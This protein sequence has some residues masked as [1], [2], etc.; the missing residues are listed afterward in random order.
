MYI[1]YRHTY[2]D[3]ER[4]TE[5]N[6]E[7]QRDRDTERQRETQGER[8]RDREREVS[9]RLNLKILIVNCGYCREVGSQ[10]IFLIFLHIFIFL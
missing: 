1:T 7:R 9:G 5:G 10:M 8:D 2:I 3:M 6:R 4:E